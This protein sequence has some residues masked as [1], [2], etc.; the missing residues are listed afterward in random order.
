MW[1]NLSWKYKTPRKTID[2]FGKWAEKRLHRRNVTLTCES[3]CGA[4]GEVN[5]NKKGNFSTHLN[6][7]HSLKRS[8]DKHEPESEQDHVQKSPLHCHFRCCCCRRPLRCKQYQSL[9]TPAIYWV[10]SHCSCCCCRCC[11]FWYWWWLWWWYLS[12]ECGGGFGRGRWMNTLPSFWT[13]LHQLTV[14]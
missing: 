1:T 13:G 3:T 8:E 2:L 9:S 14:R 7:A 12:Q 11:C 4:R 10:I 6:V 5:T